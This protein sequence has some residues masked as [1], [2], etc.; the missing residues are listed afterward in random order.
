MIGILLGASSGKDSNNTTTIH[1]SILFPSC[2]RNGPIEDYSNKIRLLLSDRP[3]GSRLSSRVVRLLDSK[4]TSVDTSYSH[5]LLLNLPMLRPPHEM[6]YDRS[7]P[8]PN[9]AKNG[10]PVVQTCVPL[11]HT[12]FYNLA[13]HTTNFEYRLTRRQMPLQLNLAQ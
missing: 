3:D 7:A 2:T 10:L 4:P 8:Y 1:L 12:Y 11:L 6:V 13:F 5:L 9:D